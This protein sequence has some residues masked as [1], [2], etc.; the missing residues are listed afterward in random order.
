MDDAVRFKQRIHVAGSPPGVEG[1]S[2]GSAAEHV[3]VRD[4]APPG[5]PLAKAPER[6][7]DA[8]PVEQR[9]GFTHAASI[10]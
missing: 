5:E 10:S 9:E 8:C 2:H 4:Y 7:L 6:I 1:E 3:K